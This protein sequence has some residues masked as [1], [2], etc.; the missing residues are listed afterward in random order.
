M[1][2]RRCRDVCFLKSVGADQVL[3]TWPVMQTI[4]VESR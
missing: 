1:I 2:G 4:G 3:R